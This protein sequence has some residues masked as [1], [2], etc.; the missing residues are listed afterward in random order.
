MK[1]S[2]LVLAATAVFSLHANAG[3]NASVIS[4][5]A[6]NVILKTYTDLAQATSDLHSKTL[7]LAAQ[8]TQENLDGAQQAWRAARVPWESSEAFLFGP[9][10]ALAIDPTLDT[11]PLN[12]RDL[13]AV[14]GSG[15]SLTVDF[16]RGLGV[17]LQGFHTVEYLLFGNGETSNTKKVSELNGRQL[18]YLMATTALLAEHAGALAHAW[19]TNADPDKPGMPG[20]ITFISAPGPRN[21]Y[22]NSEQSVLLELG[23]GMIAIVDEVG[24]GKIADPFGGDIGSANASLVESPF[25]WNSLT[26][27]TNNIRSALNVYTG[28]YGTTSGPGLREVVRRSNPALAAQIEQRLHQAMQKIQ[29]IGGPE[30]MDFRQAIFNPAARVRIEAA[31]ADLA[32]LK[33]LLERRM[34]PI[35]DN[36]D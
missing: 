12:K 24:N 3:P 26:D 35:L 30:K 4:H 19:T 18:E 14:L 21:P 11:W 13:D 27:F 6:N 32:E 29:D 7:E 1:L 22:Y 36:Q 10:S 5:V 15:R 20:F 8:P 34:I 25:S 17:N 16:V 9:V 28:D 33:T 2:S 31:M 23:H